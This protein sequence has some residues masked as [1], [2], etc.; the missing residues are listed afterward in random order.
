MR[1]ENMGLMPDNGAG[2][3][4]TL[5]PCP[6]TEDSNTEH[7]GAVHCSKLLGPPAHRACASCLNESSYFLKKEKAECTT[8]QECHTSCHGSGY[9]ASSPNPEAFWC[10]SFSNHCTHF[11]VLLTATLFGRCVV[12]SLPYRLVTTGPGCCLSFESRLTLTS[13]SKTNCP[14]CTEAGF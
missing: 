11:C 5:A 9:L 2:S 13:C 7:R 14:S 8:L 3:R 10:D 1:S 4:T 12:C 6:T